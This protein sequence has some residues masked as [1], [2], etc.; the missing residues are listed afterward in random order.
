M[1]K[2]ADIQCVAQWVRS[3]NDFNQSHVF[4][5]QLGR[6]AISSR[7]LFEIRLNSDSQYDKWHSRNKLSNIINKL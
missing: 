1:F 4:Q 7:T 3:P 6:I 5:C 2:T